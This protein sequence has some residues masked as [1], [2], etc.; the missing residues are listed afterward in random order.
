MC[1]PLYRHSLALGLSPNI[2]MIEVKCFKLDG[3]LE[4]HG[5]IR[6]D[7]RV[8]QKKL[9]KVRGKRKGSAQKG[10]CKNLFY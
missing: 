5:K 10:F 8:A 3:P 1:S 7:R 9:G 4:G 2:V 6:D